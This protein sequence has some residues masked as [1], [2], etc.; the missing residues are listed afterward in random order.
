MPLQT[1]QR[2]PPDHHRDT[3]AAGGRLIHTHDADS[4]PHPLY[5]HRNTPPPATVKVNPDRSITAHASCHAEPPAHK[6][7]MHASLPA[8]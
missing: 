4:H 5:S 2:R 6:A 3:C 8:G 7:H 1:T